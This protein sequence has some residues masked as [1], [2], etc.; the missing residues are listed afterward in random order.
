MDPRTIQQSAREFF[1][2]DNALRAAPEP[3]EAHVDAYVTT[4]SQHQE[5]IAQAEA[6]REPDT[7]AAEAA[8]EENDG[9]D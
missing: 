3:T 2:A 8:E 7:D 1:A 4:R 6:E 9:S 5:N